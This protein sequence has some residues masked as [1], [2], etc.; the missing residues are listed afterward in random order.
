MFSM[1]Y[2]Q[3]RVLE[4]LFDGFQLLPGLSHVLL[5]DLGLLVNLS[6]Y[7][8]DLHVFAAAHSFEMVIAASGTLP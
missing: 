6:D 3:H 5:D 2:L 7:Q 1:C 4:D 8:V